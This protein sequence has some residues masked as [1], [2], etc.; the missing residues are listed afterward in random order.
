MLPRCR[1]GSVNRIN[2]DGENPVS[3]AQLTRV[4]I[5][6]PDS[7]SVSQAR[8]LSRLLPKGAMRFRADFLVS[9]TYGRNWFSEWM[10]GGA[11]RHVL[12][13]ADIPVFMR[14]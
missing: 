6:L 5:R 7:V 3:I 10:L 11:T 13:W 1:S 2:H 12:M 14:H 9:D 4:N 8:P